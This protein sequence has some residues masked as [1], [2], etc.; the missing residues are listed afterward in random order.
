MIRRDLIDVG[1]RAVHYRTSGSGPPLVMLHGSPGDSQM[2]V[3]E[4][5]AC[6]QNFT[7]FALDTPGFGYSDALPGETLTVPDLA[8]ATAAAMRALNLPPCPVYGTHTGAAIAI[9]LGVGWPEQVSGLLMEGLPAFTPAEMAE[10]FRGYFAPMVADP[11]GGH[12]ISTWVR[13]RDQFTWFPWPSR[14]VRRLNALD[15]PDAAAIDLWV[16]MFYRSCKTYKPAYFA[17]CHYGQATVR[18]A[19]LRVPAIYTATVEDMLFPH[20]D[21]LPSLRP[22]QRIAPM[23][24]DFAGRIAAIVGYLAELPGGGT[25]VSGQAAAP[26]GECFVDGPYGQIFLRRYGDASL[27]ALVLLHDSPGT[28]LGLHALATRLAGTMHVIVPDH[29]GSGR[30]DACKFGDILAAAAENIVAVAD[31]LGLRQF[32]VAGAGA[33][34]AVAATLAERGDKRISSFLVADISPR[35]ATLVAPDLQFSKTGAHWVQAWLMLRD[36]QIY[37]PWYSGSVAAQRKIQ[38]NFDADWLHAQTVALM[39]GRDSYHLLPRAAAMFPTAE[40]L[41]RS[42]VAVTVLPDDAFNHQEVFHEAHP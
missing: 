20:L 9:E 11:L 15:R 39:E 8:A 41:A 18:A 28:S 14:D 21:R 2:L 4:I 10:L 30:S 33:G 35:D 1:G 23:P 36:A 31:A 27:P 6:A 7:V 25:H 13:F 26:A 40:V 37:H 22:G 38:G 29:P 19:E 24:S 34:A 5:A 12:L 16:S 42:G 17:A 3:A 32:R